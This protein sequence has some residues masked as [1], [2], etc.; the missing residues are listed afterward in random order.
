MN[1]CNVIYARRYR[2]SLGNMEASATPVT[3]HR[4]DVQNPQNILREGMSAM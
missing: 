3:R 4:S 1:T 2:Q